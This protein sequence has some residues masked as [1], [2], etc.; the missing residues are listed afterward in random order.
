MFHRRFYLLNQKRESSPLWLI[1]FSDMTTN[2]MLFFL[3][4]FAMTRMTDPERQLMIEGMEHAVSDETRKIELKGEKLLKQIQDEEA[5]ANLRNVITYGS[6]AGHAKMDVTDYEIK[7]TLNLP[8]FFATGSA[9]LN[10]NIKHAVGSLVEPLKRFPN[11]IVIEGHTDNV[12]IMGRQYR[13]NWELSIARAVS[14]INF[15]I[16]RGVDPEQLISAGYGEY[17]PAYANDTAENR[18]RNRRIE[19]NI[20][21]KQR[22]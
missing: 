1:I 10:E 15:F 17:H 9:E 16:E 22:L 5:I 7:V 12:P 14:V 21:R 6:L 13:S 20:I 19:I 3:I 4:L 18:A 8:Q 2:L 11:D